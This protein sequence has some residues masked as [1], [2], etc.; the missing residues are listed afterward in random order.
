[1]RA[2]EARRIKGIAYDYLKSIGFS[3]VYV[4][5][6]GKPIV[7]ITTDQSGYNRLSGL[8]KNVKYSQGTVFIT[9]AKV[10]TTILRKLLG[11]A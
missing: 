1:M 9:F 6:S 8:F 3:N 10:N 11:Q 4:S 2:N 7:L 5:D